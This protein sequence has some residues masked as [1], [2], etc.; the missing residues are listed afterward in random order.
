[1]NSMFICPKCKN[2][3]NSFKCTVCGYEVPRIN[4]IYQFCSDAPVKF[5]GENQYIGYDGIGEDFEPAVTYWDTNNTERYGVYEACGDL[6]A[7]KFGKGI[8]VL[9]LGAGL[10]TASIPLAKN[11][12]Y[13]IAADI[14]N[15]MLSTAVKRANGRFDKL[16][17]ARMNAYELM[18]ADN[19]V[20]IVVENAMIH[21]VD[22]PEDVIREIKRVL[23]HDG[24]LIRY[25]S[26]AQPLNKEE[27]EKNTYCNA[28]LSD[29]SD[30]YYQ[31]LTQQG[32]KGVWFDN[33]AN[34][35]IEKNFEQP[36][37]EVAESFS[38]IFTEKLKFRL[39]RMRKG[40]H[41]DLQN[42]PKEFIAKAWEAAD[43]YAKEKYGED[44]INIEGFS[45]YGAAIDLYK[46]KE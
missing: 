42:T 31:K 27:T 16:I 37:N 19:S 7:E 43:C 14:S 6:I 46:V 30:F 12:L 20:D 26:Y 34:D 2:R 21:L 39:Y 15:V 18:L 33:H 38:E 32:Y 41:S 8:T 4:F 13:T 35:Y 17:C 10:G 28:V 22:N 24:Y 9:D 45:R 25:G 3:L 1:M 5:D 40:A 36:Y 11:G 44:Y 29:I 23:K